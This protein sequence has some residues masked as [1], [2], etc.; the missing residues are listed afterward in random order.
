MTKS[1]KAKLAVERAAAKEATKQAARKAKV[2]KAKADAAAAKLAREKG[3]A[4]EE[5]TRKKPD[6]KPKGAK[7]AAGE[8]AE[9]ASQ[10]VEDGKVWLGDLPWSVDEA[11]LRT[12]FGK[13]G[14]ILLLRYPVDKAG[15]AMGTAHISYKDNVIAQKVMLL[16]GIDY[17][18]RPI[19]VRRRSPRRRSGIRTRAATKGRR[20][21]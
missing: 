12:D 5:G 4:K 2:A 15:R 6:G 9:E 8:A 10:K 18:G 14:E 20:E 1:A 7:I 3:V 13:F 16:D 19:K 11:T 21:D 17:K